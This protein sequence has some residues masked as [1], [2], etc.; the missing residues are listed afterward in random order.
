M[1]STSAVVEKAR[2]LLEERR[3]E[4]QDELKQ[5]DRAIKDLGGSS[6]SSGRGPGRPRGSRNATT[7]TR[8]RRR[9]GGTRAEQALKYL[10]ENPGMTAAEIS[11][12]LG[13]KPNYV[14]RVMAELET[15]GKVKKQGK[16]YHPVG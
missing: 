15:D 14:Y 10:T 7:T 11:D 13:I 2:T 8:R 12:K 16:T 3:S 6:R 5:I 9:R 1:A 4:L